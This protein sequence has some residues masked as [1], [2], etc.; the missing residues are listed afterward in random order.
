M[1]MSIADLAGDNA[2]LDRV[3]AESRVDILLL[4]DLKRHREG[5]GAEELRQVLSALEVHTRYLAFVRDHVLDSRCLDPAIFVADGLSV[6]E[7]SEGLL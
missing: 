6:K 3:L 2:L 7:E 5:A 4:H 1:M